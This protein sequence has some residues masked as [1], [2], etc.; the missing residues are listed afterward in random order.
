MARLNPFVPNS[1]VNPGMFVGRLE[2]VERLE[3]CLLHAKAG[4]PSHFMVTG[5]RGIGKSSLLLVVKAEAEG[6]LEVADNRLR[7]LV[8]DADIDASTTQ[9]GLVKRI[10]L[11]IKRQLEGSEP[12]RAFMEKAWQ[13]VQRRGCGRETARRTE[14]APHR[15]SAGRV[16]LHFGGDGGAPGRDGW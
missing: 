7:F 3:G 6:L 8:V 11:G 10:E 15:S 14:G 1:P 16:R 4:T 5:E 2:E 9:L 13:F 12:A